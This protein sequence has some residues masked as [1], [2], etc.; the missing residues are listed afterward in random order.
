MPKPLILLEQHVGTGARLFITQHA[1][2]LKALGYSKCLLEMNHEIP[3][4]QL[5][6]EL[7]FILKQGGP[8]TKMRRA[9]K[10]FAQMLEALEKHGIAYEFIDPETRIEAVQHTQKV[11]AAY[12]SGSKKAIEVANHVRNEATKWRDEKIVKTILQKTAEHEGGVIYLGG[13]LHVTLVHALEK[14][15]YDYRFS[16]F[17]DSREDYE[18]A[19]LKEIGLERWLEFYDAK[20]RRDYYQANVVFFNMAYDHALSFEMIEAACG[21][22]EKRVLK[23]E[24]YPEVA[25]KFEALMPGY[26]YTVDEHCMVT[27]TSQQAANINDA[28]RAFVRAGLGLRFFMEERSNGVKHVVMPGL[29]IKEN[30]QMIANASLKL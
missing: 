15:T 17:A 1:A 27:A 12:Y 21:L 14:H 6:Q 9:T 26:E 3:I 8:E 19:G 24:E 7:A 16:M 23:T 18:E 2:S 22:T 30:G 5:K 10:V 20:A 29:N 25:R 4:P 13:F 11:E 28:V